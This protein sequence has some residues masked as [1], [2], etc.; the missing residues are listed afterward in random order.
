M[1]VDFEESVSTFI[2]GLPSSLTSLVVSIESPVSLLGFMLYP[3]KSLV[4]VFSFVFVVTE[5][6]LFNLT[7]SGFTS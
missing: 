7:E 4:L 6:L 3:P 1:S 5:S 2:T